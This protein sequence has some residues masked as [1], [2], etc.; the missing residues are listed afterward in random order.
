MNPLA[1]IADAQAAAGKSKDPRTTVGCVVIDED[2]ALLASGFNGFARGVSDAAER[3]ADRDMKLKLIVHAEANAIAQAARVGA[4]LKG[5][6]MIV[7]ALYPCS[8]CANLII[9][10][11]IKRIYAPRLQ[12]PDAIWDEEKRISAMLF[13][14]AGVEIIERDDVLADVLAFLMTLETGD[15]ETQAKRDELVNRMTSV[16][17]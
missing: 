7:T 9:Q 5:G 3:Y 15:A 8:T 4:R 17:Q 6:T 11:G 1:F 2:C 13:S 10:S 12:K 14:E 16:I